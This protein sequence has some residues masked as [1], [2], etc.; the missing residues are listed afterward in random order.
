MGNKSAV[1]DAPR[2][3]RER[4][5]RDPTVGRN[6][7]AAF[8]ILIPSPGN[9]TRPNL[10]VRF[11]GRRCLWRGGGPLKNFANAGRRLFSVAGSTPMAALNATR[12]WIPRQWIAG[13]FDESLNCDAAAGELDALRYYRRN[14]N[15]LLRNRRRGGIGVRLNITR[16]ISRSLM[17]FPKLRFLG[18]PLRGW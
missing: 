13:S 6:S 8:R 4:K 3:G 16:L 2:D 9:R 10:E 17:T 5:E 11:I 12:G 15:E 7:S 1:V 18:S 14:D